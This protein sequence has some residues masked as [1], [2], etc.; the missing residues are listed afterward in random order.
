MRR[1]ETV[2]TS[3]QLDRAKLPLPGD[4]YR[5]E[6]GTLTR[7]DRKGN[8]LG[9]CPFHSS[10]SKKSFS[11]NLRTGFYFCFGCQEGGDMLR[12]YMRRYNVSF[13]GAAKALGAV[14]NVTPAERLQIDAVKVKREREAM[15]AA[16]AKEAERRKRLEIRDEVHS[17]SRIWREACDR[18]SE[19]KRGAMPIFD[20]EEEKC[21]EVMSLSLKD[22]RDSEQQYCKVSGIEFENE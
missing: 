19:L 6:L 20:G 8:A 21:W 4:F 13:L 16:D 17:A 14:Q 22:L 11:V 5:L 1:G 3:Q 10:K 18:L 7:P 12:F 15:Q 2:A 9:C